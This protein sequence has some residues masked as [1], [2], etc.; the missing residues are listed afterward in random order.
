MRFNGADVSHCLCLAVADAAVATMPFTAVYYLSPP[1]TVVLLQSQW[2]VL[3]TGLLNS[4]ESLVRLLEDRMAGLIQNVN[5]S[6]RHDSAAIYA[7]VG[8]ELAASDTVVL[9]TS[10]SLSLQ[11]AFQY[12]FER[13]CQQLKRAG[14]LYIISLLFQVGPQEPGDGS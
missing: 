5:A 10:L 14:M 7:Q 1:F 9:P 4:G 12:G 8:W 2:V 11:S 13:G 3:P 6:Y